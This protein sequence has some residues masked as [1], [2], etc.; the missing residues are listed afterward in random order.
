MT[1]SEYR[2]HEGEMTE[3]WLLGCCYQKTVRHHLPNTW[4]IP[5]WF[6]WHYKPVTLG[7]TRGLSDTFWRHLYKSEI[8]LNY[9]SLE[10]SSRQAS[11]IGH[12]PGSEYFRHADDSAAREVS[13]ENRKVSDDGYAS[14]FGSLSKAIK[15]L[16]TK[17]LIDLQKAHPNATRITLTETGRSLAAES[18]RHD[19]I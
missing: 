3:N 2:K 10:T 17:G 1:V 19:S 14:A 11:R 16:A 15:S 4:K 13:R 18:I 6:T 12:P 7:C 8:L 5:R 9:F